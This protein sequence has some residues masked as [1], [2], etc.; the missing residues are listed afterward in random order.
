[1][2]ESESQQF[3]PDEGIIEGLEMVDYRAAEGVSASD[4]KNM[5]RSPAFA[6]MRSHT[7][8]P[9]LEWGTAVHTAI[10]EPRELENRYALDPESPKG[11]Y[12]AGWRNTKD[13]KAARGEL[14]SMDGIE[15]LLTA[16][17]FEDLVHIQRRVSE[18]EIGSIVSDLEGPCEASAFLYDAEHALWRKCRP[19][20]LIPDANM[21]VDVKTAKDHRPRAF[22]RACLTYGYHISDAYYR[23]TL[24]PLLDTT[25]EHYVY[26]VV[27]S[28][29]P[30]EVAVYTLDAD[31][32][33]QGRHEYRRALAE[34]RECVELGRWPGSTEKIEELRLP[35]Y[36]ITFHMGDHS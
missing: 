30:F 19:D 14:M 36:A 25:I 23:D 33:E 27:A 3:V 34:W 17:Q 5:Q 29:A 16:Q 1:M 15:G 22:A 2:S 11:G 10:L 18:T 9:A 26:V 6:R 32:V 35:E 13:Y 20:K 21:V 7:T 4:L 28:D 24:T 12:P 8:T 31:S